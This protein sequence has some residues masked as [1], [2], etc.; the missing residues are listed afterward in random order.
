LN[1]ARVI[2]EITTELNL[3]AQR[4]GDAGRV[5]Q[6]AAA[7][8]RNRSVVTLNLEGNDVGNSTPPF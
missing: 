6:V 3:E 1:V 5:K 2:E 8:E 7:L 4:I